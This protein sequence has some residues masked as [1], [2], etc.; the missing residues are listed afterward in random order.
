[1]H[2]VQAPVSYTYLQSSHNQCLY[3][4][5]SIQAPAVLTPHRLSRYLD[6][7]QVPV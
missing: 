4:W 2:Q 3:K 5:I 6:H 7:Q 1:M